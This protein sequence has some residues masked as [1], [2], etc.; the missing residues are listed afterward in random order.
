MATVM[1]I[2]GPTHFEWRG[3][4][5]PLWQEPDDL[6]ISNAPSAGLCGEPNARMPRTGNC[7]CGSCGR[8]TGSPDKLT[9]A[10]CERLEQA[11]AQV[12]RDT[13][14]AEDKEFLKWAGI[15]VEGKCQ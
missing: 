8:S 6:D 10:K 1:T 5:D 14:A 13:I 2:L 9:C 15:K 11:L 7:V 3:K 12:E 4:P